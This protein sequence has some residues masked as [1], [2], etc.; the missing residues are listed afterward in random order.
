MPSWGRWVFL[1]VAAWSTCAVWAEDKQAF[2][3]RG[4][5]WPLYW[6]LIA[7]IGTAAFILELRDI[8]RKS[9]PGQT[10]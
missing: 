4:S 10:D 7:I 2:S 8:V 3:P 9:S 5:H 1:L 6:T